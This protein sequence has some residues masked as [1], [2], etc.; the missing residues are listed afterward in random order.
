[1][2]RRAY[3]HVVCEVAALPDRSVAEL[4]GAPA[5]AV[6]AV[7]AAVDA[8]EAAGPGVARTRTR[9]GGRRCRGLRGRAAQAAAL[10]TG[11]EH[12][13]EGAAAVERLA[14]TLG[15]ALL[16]ADVETLAQALASA[17]RTARATRV[18]CRG[19]HGLHVRRDD[20]LRCHLSVGAITGV[21]TCW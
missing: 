13:A 2:G 6:R 19:R 21:R 12:A 4:D 11:A 15:Q 5:G 1:M 20:L 8:V 17:G 14:Q 18:G 7:E 3:R 9:R 10:L 16:L